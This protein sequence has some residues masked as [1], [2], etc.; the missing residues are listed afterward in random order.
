MTDGLLE[1]VVT[2]PLSRGEIAEAVSQAAHGLASWRPTGAHRACKSVR[3]AQHD[4]GAPLPVAFADGELRW[5]P[6]RSTCE[7]V[8]VWRT[9]ARVLGA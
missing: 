2:D 1:A 3:I 6:R 8:T 5:P 7:V 4:G 9:L